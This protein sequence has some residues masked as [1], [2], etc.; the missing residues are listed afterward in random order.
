MSEWYS[1]I[2]LHPPYC[3]VSVPHSCRFMADFRSDPQLRLQRR[4]IPQ[5][6]L[7]AYVLQKFVQAQKQ[8]MIGLASMAIVGLDAALQHQLQALLIAMVK[9][10]V[11]YHAKIEYIYR[12]TRN[13]CMGNFKHHANCT[14]S[15]THFVL[16]CS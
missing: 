1:I 2:V 10:K 11:S 8:A 4:D 12:S 9:P 13:S 6:E 16:M 14:L 5:G 7:Q 3:V 15:C